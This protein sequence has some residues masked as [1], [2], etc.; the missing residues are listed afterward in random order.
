MI[1]LTGYTLLSELV[2]SGRKIN[3]M[4]IEYKNGTA[5]SEPDINRTR[6]RAYFD[7]LAAPYGY[8]RITSL[9]P[10][11]FR[12]ITDRYEGNEVIFTGDSAMSEV[13]GPGLIDDESWLFS[14][15]LVSIVD[16]RDRTKDIVYNVVP[17][18]YGDNYVPVRKRS[19]MAVGARTR[20]RFINEDDAPQRLSANDQ[21][22]MTSDMLPINIEFTG[23][24]GTY[25][26]VYINDVDNYFDNRGGAVWWNWGSLDQHRFSY[27]GEKILRN[28]GG[29]KLAITWD[30]FGSLMFKIRRTEGLESSSSSSSSVSSSSSSSSSLSSSSLSSRSSSRS[31][32]SLSSSSL[33]SSSSNTSPS[34]SLS[35]SSYSPSSSSLS[36]SSLSSSSRS[37]SSLSS[38]SRSSSSRSSS[39]RSSS[40]S[41]AAPAYWEIEL[42]TTT[43]GETAYIGIANPSP[44]QVDWGDGVIDTFNS[45]G[46]KSHVY[47]AAGAHAVR[48]SGSIS[49]FGYDMGVPGNTKLTAVGVIR[50]ITGLTRL[51]L[52]GC[53]MTSLP[54]GFLSN[55]LN[56]QYALLYGPYLQ[57]IPYGLFAGQ[58]VLSIQGIALYQNPS[59]LALPN[60]LFKGLA[61]GAVHFNFVFSGCSSLTAIPADICSYHPAATVFSNMFDGCVSLTGPA[62]ELWNRIPAPTNGT[63]CFRGCTGLSNYADI[64]AGWK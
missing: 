10:P 52:G 61:I 46:S 11:E 1:L 33:S 39:S 21:F 30:G 36:S 54:S 18:R 57:S 44:L 56:L 28:V 4:Y 32:N 53:S 35:S 42:T 14:V 6:S 26:D 8:I 60:E 41:S 12:D 27:P 24:P 3:G 64:P 16:P 15:S 7:S 37:S 62:P 58:T 55:V 43:P 31:S 19:N 45:S 9:R 38:S 22:H 48:L 5:P 17:F 20:I 47:A 63:Y 25:A 29:E 51:N 50:G 34:S 13:Y 40:S 2:S 59:L 49:T 23:E